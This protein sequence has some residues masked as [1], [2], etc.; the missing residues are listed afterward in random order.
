MERQ[1]YAINV[2]FPAS[3]HIRQRSNTNPAP[4]FLYQN[5]CAGFQCCTGGKNDALTPIL[6]E[7]S[8]ADGLVL[9]SPIYFG[10]VT[11]Q[12]RAFLERLTFPGLVYLLISM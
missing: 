9:G 10:E 4:Q 12:M 11:G 6:R 1:Q 3:L 2:I 8:R 5:S 7:I